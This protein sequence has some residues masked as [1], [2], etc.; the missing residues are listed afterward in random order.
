M[1]DRLDAWLAFAAAF[2]AVALIAW[3]APQ[4]KPAPV[5]PSTAE[6]RGTV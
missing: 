1:T 4:P 2:V 5:C 3:T 6:L